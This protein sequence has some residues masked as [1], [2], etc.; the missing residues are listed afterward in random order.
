MRE[1]ARNGDVLEMSVLPTRDSMEMMV[2]ARGLGGVVSLSHIGNSDDH[3]ST[4][5]IKSVDER[6]FRDF[7]IDG[8]EKD[9]KQ[10]KLASTKAEQIEGQKNGKKDLDDFARDQAIEEIREGQEKRIEAMRMDGNTYVFGDYEFELEDAQDNLRE[11]GIETYTR[12][13]T[14]EDAAEFAL[15]A[16]RIMAGTATPED[17]ARTGELNSNF[18]KD[19][20]KYRDLR[21]GKIADLQISSN[22]SD[23]AKAHFEI[24]DEPTKIEFKRDYGPNSE[25]AADFDNLVLPPET[26]NT[27]EFEQNAPVFSPVGLG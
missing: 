4:G 3:D 25:I 19:N 23:E 18:V 16:E 5:H 13:M 11:N 27:I 24:A 17:I 9:W 8:S 20:D 1:K 6:T 10:E 15:I 12:D 26:D 2:G 14:E 7:G 22:T 21:M